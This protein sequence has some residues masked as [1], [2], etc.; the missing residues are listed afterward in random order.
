M[1]LGAKFVVGLG[2]VPD[3]VLFFDPPA[4]TV[5]EIA[6]ADNAKNVKAIAHQIAMLENLVLGAERLCRPW[7]RAAVQ[8]VADVRSLPT[9]P[10][11]GGS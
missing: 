1:E 5:H 7:I 2:T 10:G 8:T 11:R 6:T 9:L 4:V 3:R